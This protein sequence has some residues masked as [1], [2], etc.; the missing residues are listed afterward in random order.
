[1]GYRDWRVGGQQ[2][3]QGCAGVAGVWHPF[4]FGQECR[5]PCF[6]QEIGAEL[7]GY[8]LNKGFV[9]LGYWEVGFRNMT[10]N[11]RPIKR[12]EDAKGAQD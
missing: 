4:L 11:V 1:M 7:N 9:S 5:L 3:G 8:M 2:H 6:G 10:D 12:K